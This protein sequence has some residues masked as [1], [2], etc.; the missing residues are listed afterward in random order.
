VNGCGYVSSIVIARVVPW[1]M[2]WDL[3]S[4]PL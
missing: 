1:A 3:A 4:I 2:T